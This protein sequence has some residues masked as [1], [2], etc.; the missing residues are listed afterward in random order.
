MARIGTSLSGIERTL[1]NRMA[2]AN[3][4]AAVSTLRI[5]TGNKINSA[6]D[7]PSGFVWL[8]GLQSQLSTVRATMSNVTAVGSMVTQT[9]STL[10]DIGDQLAIIRAELVKD[11]DINNPLTAPQRLEAQANIDAAILQ[12][13]TLAST[14]IGGRQLLDGSA[15]FSVSGRNANQVSGVTVYSTGGAAQTIAGNVTQL[16]EQ[17]ELTYTG[18]SGQ[19]SVVTDATFTVTGPRGSAQFT[20]A[21]DDPLSDLATEINYSSHKTG[22]TVSLAGDVLTFKSVDYGSDVGISVLADTG[23]FTVAGGNGD[24]TADGVDAQAVINDHAYTGDGTKFTVNSN[25]VHY[26]IEFDPYFSGQFD[27]ITIDGDALNFALSTDLAHSSTLAISGMQPARLGGLSGTLDELADGGS[28]SG[29]AGN[30]S[31][32]IRAVDEALADLARVEGTVDGFY[33]ASITSASALLADTE[34]N[35]EDAIDDVNLVDD[36]EE[37]VKLAYYQDLASNAVSGLAILYQQRSSIVT[38]LQAIAGLT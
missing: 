36:T 14:E 9:Q 23:T 29:L 32:A 28:L 20:V 21:E 24:G 37:S 38:M 17:A 27:T 11:E 8:S 34:D 3:A 19:A 15:D 12:I 33:N 5:A 4:A 22:V 1:L 6:G 30:T 18:K 26:Q 13:N 10:E 16:A 7:D 2:E 25:D 31:Q 35:L